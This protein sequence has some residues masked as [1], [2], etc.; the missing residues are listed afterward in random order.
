MLT[1]FVMLHDRKVEIF[2]QTIKKAFDKF[3]KDGNGTIDSGE[4]Q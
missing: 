4:L 3:D 1:H 2:D